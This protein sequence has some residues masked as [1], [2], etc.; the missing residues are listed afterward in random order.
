V[1]KVVA[2]GTRFASKRQYEIS[3][4][5]P[6]MIASYPISHSRI[7]SS[8]LKIGHALVLRDLLDALQTSR[9]VYDRLQATSQTKGQRC[10]EL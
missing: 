7:E 4:S 2:R 3:V 10:G 1:S 5:L 8:D 9:P 6:R